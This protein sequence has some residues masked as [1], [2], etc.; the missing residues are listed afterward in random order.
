MSLEK[1]YEYI[2]S[3]LYGWVRTKI[4]VAG[5]SIVLL[6]V[7]V[8]IYHPI[9]LFYSPDKEITFTESLSSLTC[10]SHNV[11]V[12]LYEL[13]IGNTGKDDIE[14]LEIIFNSLPKSIKVWRTNVIALTAASIEHYGAGLNQT[15][16]AG[17]LSFNIKD[18][19]AGTLVEILLMD[20]MMHKEEAMQLLI[21]DKQ[22]VQLNTS[23]YVVNSNPR[24]TVIGRFLES[25]F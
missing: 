12:V 3:H 15:N 13:V 25:I 4:F 22:F 2:S 21:R 20:S 17:N 19:K 23:A 5:I 18:L 10:T 14:E 8:G 1:L 24:L 6:V 16:D 7:S 11:C 9:T